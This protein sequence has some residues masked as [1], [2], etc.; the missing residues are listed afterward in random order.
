M[1]TIRTVAI[2]L[3]RMSR[4]AVDLGTAL[5]KTVSDALYK[6][7]EH[8]IWEDYHKKFRNGMHW[9]ASKKSYSCIIRIKKSL[10]MMITVEQRDGQ[11]LSST[12][13]LHS[14]VHAFSAEIFAA[15]VEKI[16]TEGVTVD[17]MVT[18]ADELYV[19]FSWGA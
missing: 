16:E 18:G 5:R 13:C 8:G 9:V 4:E 19:E 12:K 10:E 17:D 2:Y 14:Q 6:D 3:S 15:V 7:T 11:K 1:Y